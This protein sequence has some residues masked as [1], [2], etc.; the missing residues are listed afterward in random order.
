[1][2]DLAAALEQLTVALAPGPVM[3]TL[4]AGQGFPLATSFRFTL[5]ITLAQIP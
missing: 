3:P 4:L 1:V 5:I 2:A